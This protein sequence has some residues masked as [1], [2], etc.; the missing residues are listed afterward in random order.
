[1]IA[2]LIAQHHS[3]K[4]HSLS[5]GGGLKVSVKPRSTSD[6]GWIILIPVAH[7]TPDYVCRGEKKHNQ[8]SGVELKRPKGR[9]RHEWNQK[10]KIT[11]LN[12][13]IIREA[14]VLREGL[15]IL[16]LYTNIAFE[17]EVQYEHQRHIYGCIHLGEDFQA[18]CLRFYL[19]IL[20]VQF[21]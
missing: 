21:Q 12:K 17:W 19:K 16:L 13:K 18:L 8:D 3:K 2:T 4:T 1:M 15:C 20:N 9:W 14:G 11:K 6:S 10:T 5:I 7:P